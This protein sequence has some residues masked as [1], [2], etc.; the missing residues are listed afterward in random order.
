MLRLTR[1]LPLAVL[2]SAAASFPSAAS[3]SSTQQ[4]VIQDD[5]QLAANPAGTLATFR[6]LGVNRIRVTLHWYQIAPSA[7]SRTMPKHFNA[8]DPGAYPARNWAPFDA[9]VRDAAA[10]GIGVDFTLDGPAPAWAEGAGEP[11]GGVFGVWKPSATQ[12]GYFVKAVGK[13]YS[14]SYHGLPRVSNWSIWNEPNYGQDLAPQATGNDSVP[15]SAGYYRGLVAAAWGSLAGTGH[16]NRH[17]TILI[18]ELAPRGFVHPIGNYGSMKPLRFL[19]ALYCVDPSYRQLRGSA[20]AA[21]GCPTTAAASRTFRTQNAALFQAGGFADHPYASQSNPQAPNIPTS[22]TPGL[23]ADHQYADLPELGYLEGELDRL[24]GIYG[25]HTRYAIWNTEYGYRTKPPD[26]V[27]VS[28][29]NAAYYDNWGEYLSWKQGRVVS[30]NQ[31]LLVDPPSGSFASG[32]EF[33]NAKPKPGFGAFRM[34]LY[35]PFTTEKH[36][37]RVEVWGDVRPAHFAKG[38][39]SVQIQFQP[40]SH[41]AFTTLQTVRITNSRGY[42]DIRVHFPSSGS[43][44]TTWA[45]PGGP[46]IYSRTQSLTVR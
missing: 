14:G 17:D 29:S 23:R 35:L 15:V 8:T 25:S 36:G 9:I 38:T 26:R 40:G 24:N 33:S 39:Q 13:R 46:R 41:G 43:V 12:F 32:L 45:Y 22:N 44:R 4:S 42:F 16:T 20:A 1:L 21:I 2:L 28:Q 34:P 37:T 5:G 10:D 6:Q 31:Y 7:T 3:A 30:F 19:F 27:G 11:R 18:G